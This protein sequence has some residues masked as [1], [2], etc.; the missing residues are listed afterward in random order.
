MP[1]VCRHFARGYC[2]LNEACGFSH[3]ASA[4]PA[5]AVQMTSQYH[6]YGATH[7]Q[8]SSK[9]VCRHFARGFCQLGDTCGFG[10]VAVTPAPQ[11]QHQQ[12]V[13]GQ[14]LVNFL[15]QLEAWCDNLFVAFFM[16]VTTTRPP[17]K[18]C[19]HFAKGFCQLGE[20]CGFKHSADVFGSC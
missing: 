13:L 7:Q 11:W 4:V 16:Q 5:Q 8:T 20:S 14:G 10:H 17:S 3:D 1:R 2:Q 9:K 15:H 6:P 12:Q 19:R 18:V